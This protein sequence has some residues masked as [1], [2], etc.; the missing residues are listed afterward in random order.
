MTML[1]I[2]LAFVPAVG[3]FVMRAYLKAHSTDLSEAELRGLIRGL[4]FGAASMLALPLFY[5]ACA[6]QQIHFPGSQSSHFPGTLPY[7]VFAFAG[8]VLNVLGLYGCLRR[9]NGPGLVTGLF[10]C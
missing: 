3:L 4:G 7:V 10:C 1:F 2:L 8:N 9:L 6:F 5:I